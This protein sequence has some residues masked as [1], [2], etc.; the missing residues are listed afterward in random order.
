[1]YYQFIGF[2]VRVLRNAG[3][4]RFENLALAAA[5]RAGP[6][7]DEGQEALDGADFGEVERRLWRRL[8]LHLQRR[9]YGQADPAAAYY[10]QRK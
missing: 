2:C 6:K 9:Q 5:Y 3:L 4:R 1:M 8:E 10:E 7:E